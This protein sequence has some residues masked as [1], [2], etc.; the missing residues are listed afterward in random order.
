MT[1]PRYPCPYHREIDPPLFFTLHLILCFFPPF[2]D[3]SLHCCYPSISLPRLPNKSPLPLLTHWFQLCYIRM[4]S[5]VPVTR[6]YAAVS[7][8][9]PSLYS[10]PCTT[11][12]P[13]PPL[14]LRGTGW[15]PYTED[16]PL[17]FTLDSSTCVQLSSFSG[18]VCIPVQHMSVFQF[19]GVPSILPWSCWNLPWL[20]ADVPA[21]HGQ[22]CSA[23]TSCLL[24]P[25]KNLQ[26]GL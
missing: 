1:I 17:C 18:A 9:W 25:L 12:H 14:Q 8:L 10:W 21:S 20:P 23:R 6:S 19:L 22:Q 7:L 16:K 2:Q 3:P 26:P 5:G 11:P 24:L 15:G 4:K 13:K